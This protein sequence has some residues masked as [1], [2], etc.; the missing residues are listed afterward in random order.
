MIYLYMLVI[1]PH[2]LFLFNIFYFFRLYKNNFQQFGVYY[3]IIINSR[4]S[5]SSDF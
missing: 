3:L 1:L 5:S 2:I 4:I